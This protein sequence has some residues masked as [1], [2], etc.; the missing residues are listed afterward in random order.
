MLIR[1]SNA[2]IALVVVLAGILLATVIPY[3][4]ASHVAYAQDSSTDYAEN[5]TGPVAT[6]TASDQDGDPIEWSLSGPDEDKFT[7][8]GGVLAFKASP[9]YEKPDSAETGGT[10]EERNVYNVTIEAA[11]GT[12][13]VAVTVTDVDEVGSVSLTQPQPQA[14]RSL[15]ANLADEDDG[16]T[17]E[18]WQWARSS[19]GETWT[20]IEGAIAQRRD[21]TSADVGMFVRATVTYADKFGAG[22][23][24]S[25]VSSNRVEARTLANAAP[26]F[27]GQDDIEG[28]P[29]YVDIGRSVVENSAVGSNVGKPVSASDADGD[30]LI[31]S[32]VDT[33]DLEDAEETARFTIDPASGQIKV[34]KLLGADADQQEDEDSASLTPAPPV[35]ADNVNPATA[36]NNHY[37][38][39]VRATDPSTA[40]T[41]VNVIVTV[42]D[43]NEAPEFP[44]AAPK[45]LQVSE[46]T[47]AAKQLQTPGTPLANLDPAAYVPT[48]E[49]EGDTVPTTGGYDVEGADEEFFSIGNDGA[50]TVATDHTPNYEE[51]SSYSITIV[52]RSGVGT[53]RLTGRMDVTVNVVDAEDDGKVMMSQREPQVGQTVIA[54]LTDPDGKIT[55]TEWEWA[56]AA[57]DDQN[58]CPDDTFGTLITG[59][60]SAAYTPRAVDIGACLQARVTYTDNIP[61]RRQTV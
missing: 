50:L 7:I 45:T 15:E 13:D 42:T 26:S 8:G 54:T 33:V 48:D 43:A 44:E 46:L 12:H 38:L 30:I 35:S 40:S 20:D 57:F 47:S 6:F 53:R 31:Y 55:I 25:V 32:L 24:A 41:T 4:S 39:Q 5:G 2:V 60:S 58:G 21:P 27:A 19:D 23:T 52:T 1:P 3:G 51:Q 16:V 29:D 59:A 10:L 18:R 37:V 17:D 9:N 49:D 56:T 22:K 11:G 61:T 34:G 14:G 36:G 28:T